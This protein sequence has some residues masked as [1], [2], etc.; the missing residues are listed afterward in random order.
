MSCLPTG[1]AERCKATQRT[2]PP[3][4]LG[5][6]AEEEE[7]GAPGRTGWRCTPSC[8]GTRSAPP[9][10]GCPSARLH[11]PPRQWTPLGPPAPAAAAAE[12]GCEVRPPSFRAQRLHAISPRERGVSGAAP[13]LARPHCAAVAPP[14]W[15]AQGKGQLT[16]AAVALWRQ[17]TQEGWVGVQRAS[18][19]KYGV[20]CGHRVHVQAP[21][22]VRAGCWQG[23][24][25]NG[26]SRASASRVGPQSISPQH[27]RR[28]L[29]VVRCKSSGRWPELLY[30]W[31]PRLP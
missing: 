1:L 24:W 3:G 16:E 18:T 28:E 2:R 31:R 8:A 10:G 30:L 22:Q 26:I 13:T 27:E 9:W 4:L 25:W 15:G 6:A 17:A 29:C 20:G 19:T 12:A 23:S 7:L 5:Q 11:R 14:G 21:Q